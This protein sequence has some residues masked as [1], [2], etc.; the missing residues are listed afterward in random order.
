MYDPLRFA[1]IL[2]CLG[3]HAILVADNEF[4]FRRL[5]AVAGQA[6]SLPRMEV[7]RSFVMSPRQLCACLY[8]AVVRSSGISGVHSCDGQ[9][10]RTPHVG[11]NISV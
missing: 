4:R 8:E 5:A 6:R 3:E 2:R 10:V 1:G 7:L 9:Q 11:R